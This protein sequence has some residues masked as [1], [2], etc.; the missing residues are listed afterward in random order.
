M[1]LSPGIPAVQSGAWWRTG[2]RAHSCYQTII[3]LWWPLPEGS[4]SSTPP[5][6]ASKAQDASDHPP[7]PRDTTVIS[8]PQ[9]HRR[10]LPTPWTLPSHQTRLDSRQKK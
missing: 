8:P 10:H 6:A 2:R 9:G 4:R 7:H 1:M 3:S 5:E